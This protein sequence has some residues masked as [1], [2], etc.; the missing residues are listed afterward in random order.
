MKLLMIFADGF[1]DTEAIATLD[2]LQRGKIN[3]DLASL[4][5]RHEVLTKSNLKITI[6]YVIEELNYEDYDG[7]IIPGGPASFKIMPQMPIVLEMISYF[8]DNNK[9]VAAICAAPHLVGKLG[10]LKEHN[11]TVHPGFED[12]IIG[13]NYLRD[14][15]VV[16]DKNFITAKSMFYSIEFGLA[17]HNYFYGEEKTKVLRLACQGEK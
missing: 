7:I 14:K 2:V 8:A 10:Y 13:G 11:Y 3:V 1:E 6:P 4:M 12:F 9:L 17:I 15:G 5:K 16:V